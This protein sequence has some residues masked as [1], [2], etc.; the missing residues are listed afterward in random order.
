VKVAVV[1]DVHINLR[2]NEGFE[3]SR[4]LLLADMLHAKHYDLIVLNGDL[5]DSPRPTI[6]EIKLAQDF[7]D[8]LRT[9]VYLLDGNHEAID[10][11]G[12]TST[13]DF[14]RMHHCDYVKD[15][16]LYLQ[17]KRIR[18]TAWSH[19]NSLTSPVGADVLITHVRSAMPPHIEAERD[20]NFLNDYPLCIL[21]DIHS[22]YSPTPNSHYTGSPY[23]VNFSSASPKGSYIELDLDGDV[24]WEYVNTDLPQKVKLSAKVAELESFTPDPYN[25]YKVFVEDSLENLRKLRYFKNVTYVKIIKH[26][27]GSEEDIPDNVDIS[28]LLIS[29]VTKLLDQSGAAYDNTSKLIKGLFDEI[30]S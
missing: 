25:L 3:S 30:S 6:K 4:V 7:I 22:Q 26:V 9:D 24:T 29:K 11:E 17:D 1:S 8:K 12:K 19:L 14:L 2:Q 10:V 27:E 21:G 13:Y 20:M 28:E 16:V 23:A 5:L 15:E 18:S